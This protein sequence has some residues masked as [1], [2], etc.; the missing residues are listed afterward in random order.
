LATSTS[1]CSHIPDPDIAS[2]VSRDD[3]GRK[4]LVDSVPL[5]TVG[6]KASLAERASCRIDTVGN[7]GSIKLSREALADI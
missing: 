5:L 6:D 3:V 4:Y 1:A 2:D 7:V